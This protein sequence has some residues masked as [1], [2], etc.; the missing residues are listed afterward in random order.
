[1]STGKGTSAKDER[2]ARIADLQAQQRRDEQRRNRI[3]IAVSVLV[4]LALVIPAAIIIIGEQRRQA[5]LDA[6]ANQPIEGVQEF[7]DL[8]ATHTE[9][10]VEYEQQPPVGGDHNPAWQNCGFY[11]E[12]VRSVHA[13]HSLEH[14]AVWV[15]YSPDLPQE[16]VSQ[17]E[18]LTGQHPYLLVSPYEDL[19]SPIVASAWGLQLELDSP[20]DERLDLFLRKYLQGPQTL[21]PGASCSGAVGS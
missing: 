5:D 6:A 13:V 7:A 12:P 20:D 4:A 17:L 10:D 3:I 15:T 19:S 2:R 18:E 14:G 9:D 21:E 11:S 1:V 8:S 16:Q